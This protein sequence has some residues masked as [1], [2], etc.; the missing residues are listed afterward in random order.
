MPVLPQL[1]PTNL[2]TIMQAVEQQMLNF[3]SPITGNTIA[4]DISNIYW[5]E[6]GQEPDPAQTGQRDILLQMLG[7][8]PINVQGDGRRTLNASGLT[9]YLRT[10]LASD[11]RG[12]RRDWMIAHRSL[13][14]AL[15][16]A[17]MGFFPVDVNNNALTNEGFVLGGPEGGE[18]GNE[19]PKRVKGDDKTKWG[20]TVGTYRFHYLLNNAP[21]IFDPTVA[22]S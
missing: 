11:R 21:Q 10:T 3:N 16:S 12:T 17:M 19:T 1:V 9:I 20:E 22:A 7:D 8:V 4:G 2:P 14:D 5:V 6:V 13:V 18:E 15:M